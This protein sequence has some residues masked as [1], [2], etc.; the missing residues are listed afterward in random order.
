MEGGA[1]MWLI[2]GDV[3]GKDIVHFLERGEHRV[4]G[5][6]RHMNVGSHSGLPTRGKKGL[7]TIEGREAS[8]IEW[9]VL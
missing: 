3:E 9:W 6:K 5:K 4:V 7:K 1:K 2:R 8:L